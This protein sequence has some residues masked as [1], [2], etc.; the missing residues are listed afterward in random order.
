[1]L[2]IELRHG[3]HGRTKYLFNGRA[4]MPVNSSD[5]EIST[6]EEELKNIGDEYLTIFQMQALYDFHRHRGLPENTIS[7][8]EKLEIGESCVIL[9][10]IANATIKR[11]SKS[12]FHIE[13]S[14]N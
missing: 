12:F 9:A 1:M 5:K 13:W 4:Y 6:F 14:L 3:P 7:T 10:H 8:L 11:L 2:L